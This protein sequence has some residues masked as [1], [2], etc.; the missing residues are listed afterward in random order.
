MTP[1]AAAEVEIE[2]LG[3]PDPGSSTLAHALTLPPN[4]IARSTNHLPVTAQLRSDTAP[5]PSLRLSHG[6]IQSRIR[7]ALRCIEGFP[8]SYNRMLLAGSLDYCM[9]A[10]RRAAGQD[11]LVFQAVG[12]YAKLAIGA[13]EPYVMHVPHQWARLDFSLLYDRFENLQVTCS[14]HGVLPKLED[15]TVEEILRG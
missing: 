8:I 15:M 3:F 2:D 4:Q 14:E 10:L 11:R 7:D 6:S 9:R 13:I 5:S 12:E 1:N